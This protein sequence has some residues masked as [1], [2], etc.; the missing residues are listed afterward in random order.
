M[1]NSIIFQYHP[2]FHSQSCKCLSGLYWAHD[3]WFS[4]S[5][6]PN[7]SAVYQFERPVIL[8]PPWSCWHSWW[9]GWTPP[10]DRPVAA[11]AGAGGSGGWFPQSD[12]RWPR[13]GGTGD[14]SGGRSHEWAGSP[15]ERGEASSSAAWRTCPACVPALAEKKR[16]ITIKTETMFLFTIF[17][18]FESCVLSGFERVFIYARG[19]GGWALKI[20]LQ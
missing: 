17:L 10:V 2:I 16:K 14:R 9:R 6:P 12:R 8:T 19:R 20:D 4:C 1:L 18:K 15:C 13:G 3:H 11:E 5:E 7:P